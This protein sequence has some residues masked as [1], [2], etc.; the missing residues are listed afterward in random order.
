MISK[1]LVSLIIATKNA[2][3][4]IKECLE[5]VHCRDIDAVEIIIQ[6]SVSEDNTVSTIKQE[7]PLVKVSSE[8]DDGI[9]DAFNKAMKRANGSYFYFLGSD[10]RLLPGFDR[11]VLYLEQYQPDIL[12]GNVS[13]GDVTYAGEFDKVKLA[14][15]N[16]SHQAIFYHRAIFDLCGSYK[17]KYPVLA[18]YALNIEAFGNPNLSVEYIDEVFAQFGVGGISGRGKWRDPQ[19]LLDKPDLI[20]RHLGITD[21]NPAYH[22]ALFARAEYS[23]IK[24][25]WSLGL[26]DMLNWGKLT[27]RN[28]RALYL[29]LACTKRRIIGPRA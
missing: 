11:G 14:N 1:P 8:R 4:N 7:F 18:D 9:Y 24:G 27:K 12:Y 3:V 6:D 16:V 26:K 17:L 15:Q 13:F 10:D 5:S 19:F 23:L 25:K 22:N 21:D 28:F 29:I 20:S 2:E